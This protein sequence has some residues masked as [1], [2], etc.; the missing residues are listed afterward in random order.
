MRETAKSVDDPLVGHGP[1][2]KLGVIEA[3]HQLDAASLHSSIFRMFEGEIEKRAFGFAEPLIESTRNGFLRQRKRNCIAR[4]RRGR[5]TKHVA[6][7]LVEDDHG[8]KRTAL[9]T[10]ELLLRAQRELRVQVEEAAAD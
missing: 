10:E 4:K 6:R 3:R 8:C 9:I 2:G 1:F 7:H 5:I